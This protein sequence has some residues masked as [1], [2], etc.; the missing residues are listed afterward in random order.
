MIHR[1]KAVIVLLAVLVLSACSLFGEKVGDVPPEDITPGTNVALG[2][3]A[4]ASSTLNASYKAELAVD[5]ITDTK[6]SRWISSASQSPPHW[7]E[8]DLEQTYTLGGAVVWTGDPTSPNKSAV[9]EYKLQYWGGS[10][11]LD[12]P[13]A[14]VEN[15]TQDKVE[16]PFSEPVVTDKVRFYSMDTSKDGAVRVREIEIYTAGEN[17]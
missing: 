15:N 2:K 4:T 5:G 9:V 3:P 8:I 16:L 17:D 6:E 12:I 11:W 1:G 13:G 10:E 7:L 14:S